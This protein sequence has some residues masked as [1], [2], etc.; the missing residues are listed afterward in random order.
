MTDRVALLERL[1]QR[2]L[3]LATWMIRDA[4]NIRDN[5]AMG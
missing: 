3:W 5:I 1:E 2:V 4:N